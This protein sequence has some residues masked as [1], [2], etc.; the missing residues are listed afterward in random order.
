[1]TVKNN[2][3][4]RSRKISKTYGD[5]I[6]GSEFLEKVKGGINCEV[7]LR[8]ALNIDR[9][10]QDIFPSGFAFNWQGFIWVSANRRLVF[11]YL[12]MPLIIIYKTFTNI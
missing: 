10:S 4:N 7:F 9:A 11:I 6:W 3:E 1:M 12:H 8:E 5:I 2:K